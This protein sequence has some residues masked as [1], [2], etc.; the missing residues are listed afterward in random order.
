M[1]SPVI[2]VLAADV[3]VPQLKYFG[4]DDHWTEAQLEEMA[5]TYNPEVHEAPVTLD[6]AQEGPSY[7]WVAKLEKRDKALFA[8]LKDIQPELTTFVQQKKY[9]K[10]SAEV[11][12]DFQ[13]GGKMY[14]RGVSFLGAGKPAVK[15]MAD[16]MLAEDGTQ[17]GFF[18][19]EKKTKVL[20]A[21]DVELNEEIFPK[22]E[23]KGETKVKQETE[24]NEVDLTAMEI[25]NNR[26]RR[27]N[28]EKEKRLAEIDRRRK[29]EQIDSDLSE[30]C[31][32]GKLTP[33]QRKPLEV[34]MALLP[35]MKLRFDGEEK[36]PRQILLN[37]VENLK[38]AVEFGALNLG[39]APGYRPI[40]P[41]LMPRGVNIEDVDKGSAE[42][43]AIAQD[44]QLRDKCDYIT[45]LR[46]AN[47]E[48]P[49]LYASTVKTR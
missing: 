33:A 32:K 40:K 35:D 29:L 49:E 24:K 37:F 46:K 20:F 5:A 18:S 19:E 4:L 34:I 23:A 36:T 17:V 44:I 10:I 43:A 42:L 39:D 16:P 38:P 1:Q 3:K 6:H 12:L 28:T 7:G 41:S 48:H 31:D 30:L 21:S 47:E 27:E 14:L 9:K 2:Q 22:R 25:E 13:G 11:D 45:A 26:L 8:H 15:G